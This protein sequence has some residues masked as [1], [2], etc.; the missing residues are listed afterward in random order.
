[1]A[2]ISDNPMHKPH[3]FRANISSSIAQLIGNAL[4]YIFLYAASLKVA[5]HLLSTAPDGQLSAG[6]GIAFILTTI[7]LAFIIVRTFIV[8]HD[9]AHNAYFK[10]VK[11]NKLTG[12]LL[13]VFTHVPHT[14]WKQ[15][16][17]WH[18][19]HSGNLQGRNIGDIKI[20][21][22][23]EY[24][25]L[26][27]RSQ[28]A[29]RIYRNPFVMVILGSLFQFFIWFKVPNAA[30]RKNTSALRSVLLTD[31]MIAV[32]ITALCWFFGW[33]AVLLV[34]ASSLWIA[35]MVAIILF[36]IQHNYD[37]T[38]WRNKD[39]WRHEDASLKGSSFLDL[40]MIGHW[41]TGNIGYHHMHHLDARIPNYLLPKA[42]AACSEYVDLTRLR[43][44]DIPKSFG[45]KL[46][47]EETDRLVSFQA[48]EA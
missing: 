45:L 16:H 1:M 26:P 35:G 8:Q 6:Y 23:A 15:Q 7:F 9:C 17:A 42:H 28:L 43:F 25:A 11:H 2:N 32:R 48:C 3:Q 20:L 39:E 34:E 36:Y 27:K 18:H 44:R 30:A 41:L 38:Y 12:V 21:T 4:L 13:S 22:K 31:L 10:R 46:W 40:G 24:A 19:A 37:G 47:D 33:Q 14:Y 29:Y 5:D